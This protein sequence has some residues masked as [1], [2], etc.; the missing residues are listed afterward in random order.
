MQIDERPACRE[1]GFRSHS[2][3]AHV[4]E[5][6]LTPAEYGEKHSGWGLVSPLLLKEMG[7]GTRRPAP[8]PEN[9]TVTVMGEEIPVDAGVAPEDCGRWEPHYAWPTRGQAKKAYERIVRAVRRRRTAFIWG[10]PGTG[11]DSSIHQISAL[12]RM[13]LVEITFR[14][15]D[16]IAPLFYT[17]SLQGGETGWEYGFVWRAVTEG[18]VGRDGVARP[19]IVLLSDVDRADEAQVEW[20]RILADSMGGRIPAPGGKMVPLF[21]GTVFICTAN[22]VGSGDARGRMTSAKSIDGSIID[23]LGRGIRAE[24]LDW[25]DEVGVLMAKFPLVAEHLPDLF[26]T[27]D[28]ANDMGPLGS[29]VAS[30]RKSIAAE[31]LYAEFTHRGICEVLLEIQDILE[32]RLAAGKSAPDDIVKRGWSAWLEKLDDSTADEARKL[33]DPHLKGGAV[34]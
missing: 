7:R 14:P 12:A 11:K 28:E 31:E 34:F 13:P 8:S 1:C 27:G 2:L 33:I 23:R 6:G 21:P 25:K 32:D 19:A 17:R 26:R 30:L 3:L 24:Y 5:H 20:F 9:L 16:D 22:S 10:Q 4:G 15:G 29:A 18:I